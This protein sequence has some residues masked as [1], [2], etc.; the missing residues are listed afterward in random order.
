LAVSQGEIIFDPALLAALSAD[1]P[2]YQFLRR[3]SAREVEIMDLL[4]KG[5]TDS[6]IADTLDIDAKTV[7]QHI[8]GMYGRLKVEA[9]L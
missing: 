6:S 7:G 4:S 1:A 3:L 8:S 9:S 2:I 5:Y